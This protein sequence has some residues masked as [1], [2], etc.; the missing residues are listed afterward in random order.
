MEKK[1]YRRLA[2]CAFCLS[3]FVAAGCGGAAALTRADE[4]SVA[5]DPPG[6]AVYAA[7]NR[8]GVTPLAVRQ[9]DIFPVVYPPERQ[10]V[11]GTLLL[12]K[13]GCRDHTVRVTNAVIR[14]GVDVKLDCGTPVLA[15]PEGAAPGTPTPTIKERL[16]RLNELR[17]QGLVTEE[18]YREI[19]GKILGE[20]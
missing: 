11:Y 20:L 3:L 7:G 12:S 6:A 1:S 5:S 4:V 2:V 18:E 13:E 16:L 10:D 14:K 8:I 17:E 9:H 19:R 15:R